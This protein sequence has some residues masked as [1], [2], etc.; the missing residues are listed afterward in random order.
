MGRK[1]EKDENQTRAMVHKH[2]QAYPGVSYIVLKNVYNLTD[3]TLRYHL[4][5]LERKDEI[6]EKMVEGRKCYFPT[7]HLELDKNEIVFESKK[8]TRVQEKILDTIEKHPGISQKDLVMRSKVK[9]ITLSYNVKKLIET[10][11]IRKEK[12]GRNI[13]YYTVNREELRKKLLKG[14]VRKLANKEISEKKFNALKARLD[15]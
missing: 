11:Y 1:K 14:L 10:C 9:R 2:I 13:C 4:T 8:L 3:G 5:Y 6:T 15:D 12:D 7:A